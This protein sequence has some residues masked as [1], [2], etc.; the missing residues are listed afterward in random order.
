[1]DL[2]GKNIGLGKV[3]EQGAGKVNGPKREK[4]LDWGKLVNRVLE[5]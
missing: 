5:K 3:C 2:R 1:M 4:V